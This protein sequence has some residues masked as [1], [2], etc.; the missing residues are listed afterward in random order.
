MLRF[1]L[2]KVPYRFL[3]RPTD[4]I[5][6]FASYHSKMSAISKLSITHIF[7]RFNPLYLRCKDL[8][9]CIVECGVGY[10]RSALL[11]ESLL[12]YYNDKSY[13]FLFDSFKGFPA[14]TDEDLTSD[15]KPKKGEWNKI[16][17][18]SLYEMLSASKNDGPGPCDVETYKR[19]EKY[20]IKIVEGFFADS[21]TPNIINKIK[22]Q[23]GIKFLHL[24]VDLYESYKQTLEVL[25][26]L[27]NK[28]G[29]I[30]LDEYDEPADTKFPGARLAIDEYLESQNLDPNKVI[31]TDNMG[32]S[33]LI[34]T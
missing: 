17:P 24:D 6:V 32:K 18:K 7:D 16:G 2:Q 28:G 34:K 26:P 19:D 11:I 13:F 3:K 25:F 33:Y 15:I 10:G 30:L 8:E 5:G 9:G 20:R 1:F 22:K 31:L 4:K 21:L 12:Q 14:P 23:K 27:V 29:V